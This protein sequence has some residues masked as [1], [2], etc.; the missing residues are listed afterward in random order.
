MT[1]LT[2]GLGHVS[3]SEPA[4]DCPLKGE[5]RYSAVTKVKYGNVREAS[6]TTLH[7]ELDPVGAGSPSAAYGLWDDRERGK[8]TSHVWAEVPLVALPQPTH[9]L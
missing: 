4:L 1:K 9:H 6:R 7:A 2:V 5:G 3:L 8:D